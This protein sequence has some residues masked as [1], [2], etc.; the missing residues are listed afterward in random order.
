MSDRTT[1]ED[2]H[3]LCDQLRQACARLDLVAE[4]IS[5][6]R[7]RIGAPGAGMLSEV[8]TCKPDADE[9]LRWWW[10]WGDPFCRATHAEIERAA[11]MIKHV[12]APAGA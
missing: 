2:V 10:S 8:I 1:E 3:T 9:V 12:V 7:V 4:N 5:P 6:T 11:E